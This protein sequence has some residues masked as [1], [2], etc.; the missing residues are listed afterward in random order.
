M[1]KL[2][3]VSKAE[4]GRPVRAVLKSSHTWTFHTDVVLVAVDEDDVDW[5]FHEDGAELDYNW[6]VIYW[7]YI[8]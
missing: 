6:D 4:V 1:A 3:P 5:R 8:E 7:E 2:L